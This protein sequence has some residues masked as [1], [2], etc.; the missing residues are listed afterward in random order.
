MS[1]TFDRLK[2]AL[3]DRY[4]IEREIGSGGMAT[5]YLAEDLK[6]KRKV[7]VKV[8]RPELA[9]ALGPE[10]FLKEIEIAAG[11]MQPH[12]LPLHDSGEADGFL[13]YVMPFVEGES[14]RDKLA[15]G[16]ELPIAD[17]VRILREVVDALAHSHENNVVHR[18]IKPDNVLLSGRH[19]LVT[20]FGVAKAVSEATGRNE[21]TT[22]GVALGT[23]AYMAPEQAAA[24]PHIDHRAD[25]YAVGAVAY[26]L[27]TGRPPFTGNTQQ[28]ILAAHVTQTAEPVTKYRDSVP[29]ALEQLITQCLEKK[30]ADRWQTAEELLPQLEA[31]ATPSG[32]VTPT[33]ARLAAGAKTVMRRAGAVAVASAVIVAAIVIGALM[34]GRSD[35]TVTNR[36]VV[37]PFE[38]RTGDPSLDHLSSTTVDWITRGLLETGLLEVVPAQASVDI[39]R[40]LRS[41]EPGS[42]GANLPAR[43]A[44]E[45]GA[46]L[47]VAGSYYVAADSVRFQAELTDAAADRLLEALEPVNSM[48]SDPLPALDELRRRVMG[49]LSSH[50]DSTLAAYMAGSVPPKSYE[51]YRAFAEAQNAFWRDRR[52]SKEMVY[53]A[54]ALDSTWDP[55]RQFAAIVH[56]NLGEDRQAD[57]IVRLLEADPSGLGPLDRFNL[58]WVRA[59]LDGNRQ[60]A[61]RAYQ[62]MAEITSSQG[63]RRQQAFE[64]IKLNRLHEALEILEQMD[65]YCAEMDGIWRYW[66]HVANALHMLG[67]HSE[68][69]EET[70]RAREQYPDLLSVL[71]LELR[72]LAALGR[73]EEVRELL[74]EAAT[75]PPQSGYS[76]A[77]RYQSAALE[78]LAH[79]D[80]AA[81]MSLIEPGVELYRARVAEEGASRSLR[82]SLALWLYYAGS[83]NEAKD[84]YEGLVE[85]YPNSLTYLGYFGGSA[86]R[87]G[88]RELALEVSQRIEQLERPYD[89]GGKSIWRSRIAAALG[90]RG[91][92]V[93]L[94]RQAHAEGAR[95]GIGI[96]RYPEFE[97]L[98]GFGPYEELMEPKG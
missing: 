97:T 7:A 23:P 75:L 82:S 35:D 79:G 81:A 53:R 80:T 5:V 95:Y 2:S 60:A 29:P 96:H 24:D 71:E 37:V 89:I 93:R 38:N 47:V 67:R 44:M 45:T 50:V 6:H 18:D 41:R 1:D 68:E 33:A 20:D 43:V 58:D 30:A 34:L 26:E 90:L 74:D 73:V 39:T 31:L 55:A 19:A 12:I 9:A 25:I 56:L 27:L 83:W 86:A 61:Y 65:P 22:A 32:G 76:L 85:E 91:E 88:D 8:L 87:I 15:R 11:L 40:A 48:Q 49:A 46:R 21:L 10:R 64:A 51:A 66:A 36:V 17:A 3:S 59:S 98:R 69:L 72:A 92:A 77:A 62:Q 16:G 13:F 63:V 52:Q 78:F 94:L 84:L 70:R 57:S 54:L 14:L 42:A 28:E 4:A